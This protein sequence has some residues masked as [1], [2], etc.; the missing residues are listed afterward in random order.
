MRKLGKN[1]KKGCLGESM[2]IE[3]R[4][5]ERRRGTEGREEAEEKGGRVE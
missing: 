2:K 3:G 4:S 5:V 1:K